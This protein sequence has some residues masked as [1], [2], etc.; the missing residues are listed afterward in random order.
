MNVN[1]HR[2]LKQL[3]VARLLEHPDNP[4]KHLGDLTEL[5]E[6]VRT[7][8]ILQNLTVTPAELVDGVNIPDGEHQYYV[9]IIGHRRLAAAKMAGLETVPCADISMDRK[10]QLSTMLMEN[11][12]RSDLTP[13][14]QAWGFHQMSLLGCTVEEIA[15]KSGFS[16]TTVRRRLEIARLDEV[17]LKEVTQ[18]PERQ[19]S[20][21]DFEKLAEIEDVDLRNEAL[22]DIGTRNFGQAVAGANVKEKVRQNMPVIRQ[23]M[24]DNGIEEIDADESRR[25]TYEAL[26]SETGKYYGYIYID[27]LGEPANSLP[28]AEDI[29]DRKVYACFNGEDRFLNLYVPAPRAKAA[30]KSR[31]QLDRERETRE[32]KRKIRDLSAMH[33]RMRW[34]FIEKLKVTAKNREAVLMGGVLAGLHF[35]H[36]HSVNH[37]DGVSE[38]LGLE[39]YEYGT[40]NIIQG[41]GKVT[42]TGKGQ[43]LLKAVY[44]MYKDGPENWFASY[45]E[46]AGGQYPFWDKREHNTGLCLLYNWLMLLGYEMSD[47]EAALMDGSHEL[48]KG[49]KR[50]E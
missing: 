25:N 44:A 15:E 26:K 4:R 29:G 18:D 48:Y 38:A 16:Q 22:K 40:A 21:G 27:R 12:Q 19:I 3:P 2:S 24:K 43:Q 11:M 35:A 37:S 47:D 14:E 1:E 50:K 45:I 23:W 42:D 49:E 6:S 33:Y 17:L 7:I 20:M 36:G 31:E 10:E 13:Y 41:I 5:A 8:G 28:T 30:T 34:E 39:K 32:I 46:N 9:V